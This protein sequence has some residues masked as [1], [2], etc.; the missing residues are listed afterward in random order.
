[1]GNQEKY[2]SIKSKLRKLN[3]LAQGGE[4][5]EAKNAQYLLDKLCAEYGV[6]LD[7]ILDQESKKWYTF[8]VGA[9]NVL[10]TLFM[11]CYFKVTNKSEISYNQYGKASIEVELTA[12]EYA[13]IKSLFDWH[14]AN[15][16]KD[17]DNM[18]KTLVEAY[19][20]KHAL[21]SDRSW[22]DGKDEDLH[23]TEEDIRRILVIQAMR[24]NLSNNTY[25]KLLDSK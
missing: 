16:Q 1:M 7:E 10:K 24:K 17:V 4:E 13:E 12:Y 20:S 5:G 11:Q 21:Y 14:K 9:R 23:L 8:N 19:C 6:T 3:A 22:H 2:E 15:F 18:L 25:C